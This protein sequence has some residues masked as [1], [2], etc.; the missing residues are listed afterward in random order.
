VYDGYTQ[1]KIETGRCNCRIYNSAA[2]GGFGIMTSNKQKFLKWLKSEVEEAHNAETFSRNGESTDFDSGIFA[3]REEAFIEIIVKID[4]DEELL[5]CDY[6]PVITG[7]DAKRFY[8]YMENPPPLTDEATELIK[9][10]QEIALTFCF[11][12]KRQKDHNK[13]VRE[14]L[15]IK[16]KDFVGSWSNEHL[17]ISEC[18]IDKGAMIAKLDECMETEL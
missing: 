7:E 9:H 3:G 4:Q 1:E 15:I 8:E 12:P 11:D 10:A 18:Y 5:K 14:E 16:L 2:Y 17:N 6:C 13:I